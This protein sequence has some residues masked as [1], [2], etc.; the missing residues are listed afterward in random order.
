MPIQ[1]DTIKPKPL[2]ILA[3]SY[4][5]TGQLD[6]V[7]ETFLLPFRDQEVDRIRI[8]SVPRFPFPWP[9]FDFFNA[10][11]ETVLEEPIPLEPI[12]YMEE[13]YDLVVLGYQPW[14]LSPSL[15][16]SSLL[17]DPDFRSRLKG[18]PVVTLSAGRNM[19]L[20]A[21]ES[22][23]KHIREAGGT[24]VANIPLVDRNLNH[25]SVITIIHWLI[26]G[27]KDRKWGIF[28]KPG[29]SDADIAFTQTYG[30]KVRA[31]LV[32]QRWVGLQDQLLSFGKI[33]VPTDILFI[34]ERAKRLFLI[35]AKLI[36]KKGN[37]P[38]RRKRWVNAFKYYL[39]TALFVVAPLL[40]GI[41]YI[42]VWP[43]TRN[44]LLRKKQYFCGVEV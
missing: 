38:Q 32:Q 39:L 22:V 4:S 5:Q 34:E 16:I 1:E 13:S 19:W 7:I 2:K 43:F 11:P 36:K 40:L 35:W 21:Q 3:V 17:Q 31:A 33:K 30:E 25:V 26:G 27:R 42:T 23:R 18:T 14:F 10:M 9:T 41:Y 29:V 15:P 44:Q 37:T 20:N 12:T 8:E 24:L 28:P 6:Q